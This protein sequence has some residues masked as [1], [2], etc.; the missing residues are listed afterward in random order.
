[1]EARDLVLD[2]DSELEALIQ[3]WA[4]GG[5]AA[6]L[7]RDPERYPAGTRNQSHGSR[8]HDQHQLQTRQS[9]VAKPNLQRTTVAR[10]R[11]PARCAD[12]VLKELFQSPYFR[13]SPSRRGFFSISRNRSRQRQMP[14]NGAKG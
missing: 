13:K 10:P 8:L 1:M 14:C 9:D 5:R 11:C 12:R 4:T 6:G 2:S 3:F 7:E